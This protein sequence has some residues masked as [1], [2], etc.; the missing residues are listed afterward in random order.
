MKSEILFGV[1]PV[2]E[3]VRAARREVMEIIITSGKKTGRLSDIERLALNAGIRVN[4]MPPDRLAAVSLSRRHQGV[5]ARVSPLPLYDLQDLMVSPGGGKAPFL[6]LMDQVLDPHNLG[7]II[8]TALCTGVD[9]ILCPRDRA[10]APTPVVSRISAGAMEHVRLAR[11]TNLVAAIKALKEKR[12]W[13]AGMDMAGERSVFAADFSGPLA[14]VIG[15]EE[16]GLRPLVKKQCD[17]LV[18]IPQANTFNSLNASVA[19]AVVMYEAFRQRR[20]K[21]ER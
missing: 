7:A 2:H 14:I 13:V 8:R 15:G 12:F 11:V 5:A 18:S 19:G 16:K 10:A 20:L 9:G 4:Q 3:A 1:H 17:F 21:K 6:L